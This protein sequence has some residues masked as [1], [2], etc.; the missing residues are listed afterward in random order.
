MQIDIIG[1]PIDLGADRR[2]VDMGPSAIRYAH[3]QRKLEELGYSVQD[4]GNVEVP[5]AEMCKITNP[6][7]KYIDCII[8]MSR[9]VAGAVATS[10]QGGRFPL[11][12]GGD[13]SLSI[14]SVRG[15]ARNK[16]LGVIWIDAHADFNTAETTPSGNIHGMSLAVLAGQGDPS[17]VQLWDEPL[18]VIDPTKIAIIGARDLDSGEKINLQNAGAMVLGMEQIDRYGMVAMVEKAIEHVSRD[19]DG[20]WLS[21]DLDALDP[22][23]APGVGTPVPAGLT[24]REA[25][26]ACELIAETGKLIGMDLVEVNPILDV[27]NQTATRAVEFALSALGRRIWNGHS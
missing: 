4:E 1:V 9:R 16:K 14:G 11:V 25:H 13:H 15:A 6:K 26:L 24:Q 21:L 19:V 2:G 8:P 27:Q 12:L 3:L 20:I 17:L 18:P 7:L 23:H 10:V 22:Q 5:I